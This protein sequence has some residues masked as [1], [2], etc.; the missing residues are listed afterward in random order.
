[1]TTAQEWEELLRPF[2]IE[3][4][5]AL[6]GAGTSCR[7]CNCFTRGTCGLPY[8]HAAECP[9]RPIAAQIYLQ[10]TDGLP[11]VRPRRQYGDRGEAP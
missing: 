8:I 7:V 10:M 6:R 1:M 9:V 2:G 11:A 3:A 4:L 5:C